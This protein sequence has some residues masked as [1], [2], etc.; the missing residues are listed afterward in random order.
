MILDPVTR[1]STLGI[2]ASEESLQV[3]NKRRPAQS[4]SIFQI[5]CLLKPTNAQSYSVKIK[6][7]PI[8]E[9]TL[10]EL[11]VKAL[12]GEPNVPVT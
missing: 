6:P 11:V 12:V 5:I 1:L 4:T 8:S 2:L 10:S 7:N 9:Q 3:S